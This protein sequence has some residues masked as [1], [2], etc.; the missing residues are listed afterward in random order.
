M[1][2]A[3][4]SCNARATWLTLTENGRRK[5]WASTNRLQYQCSK[6][7]RSHTAQGSRSSNMSRATPVA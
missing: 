2:L 1:P 6:E 7:C 5:A 3:G 4:S